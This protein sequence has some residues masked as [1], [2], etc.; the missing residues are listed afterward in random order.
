[1]SSN[2]PTINK[3]TNL[4]TDALE[5][6]AEWHAL[7]CSGT[8]NKQDEQRLQHWL[9]IDELN[10]WAWQRVLL[11]QEKLGQLPGNLAEETIDRAERHLK[12]SR[13]NILKSVA[14]VVGTGAIGWSVS[15]TDTANSLLAS[16]ATA[17]GEIK[18]FT[19]QDGTSLIMNT[20]SSVD[21]RFTATER[22]LLLL[23]GEIMITTAKDVSARPFIVE[24]HAGQIRALG[25]R[26]SVRYLENKNITKV[27]VYQDSVEITANS[28]VQQI[29]HA[30]K[31]L[32][33]NH[34]SVSPLLSSTQS[35][36]WT[37]ELLVVNDM[38]LDEFVF[39]LSRYR[40]GVLSIDPKAA[41]HRISGA[42]KTNNTDQALSAI[43][44]SFPVT[45]TYRTKYW[46]SISQ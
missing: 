28:G 35:D 25:T 15:R 26:F 4:Q 37:K 41:Q 18:T 23:K 44:K 20:A 6:A 19:L 24:T 45:I 9:E 2:A 14:L 32:T 13:R 29:C 36:A 34:R 16:H 12:T 11:L 38:R 42:F 1:M 17:T 43:Q 22:R 31:Q 7:L 39:E 46:V 40:P 21:V 33:F 27:N 8:A 3:P 10:Q 5:A 30:G